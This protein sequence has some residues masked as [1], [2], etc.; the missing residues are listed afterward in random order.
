[1]IISQH[2]HPHID[3]DRVLRCK[4]RLAALTEAFD[5]DL[6]VCLARGESGW[7]LVAL[8]GIMMT[9]DWRKCLPYRALEMT[10][11]LGRGQWTA[12]LPGFEEDF[13]FH[14]LAPTPMLSTISALPTS[15]LCFMACKPVRRGAYQPEDVAR[16]E[17]FL[18]AFEEAGL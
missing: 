3:P 9:E 5:A 2:A 18:S 11:K 10:L 6:A 16:L 7:S 4:Q 12:D 14:W 1:M 15:K 17:R 8:D 13:R